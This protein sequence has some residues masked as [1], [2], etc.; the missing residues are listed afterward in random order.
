M[1][2]VTEFPSFTLTKAIQQRKTL[3]EAGKTPEEVQGELGTAFKLE[4]EKLTCLIN[5][6]EIASKHSGNLKRIL[7]M[8]LG[9]GETNTP[10]GATKIDELY[11]LPEILN[12][13]V[14]KPHEKSDPKNKNRGGRGGGKGGGKGGPKESPWGLSPEEKAAKNKKPDGA[15]PKTN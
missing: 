7:V 14:A 8:R 2:A 11:Y 6:V 10:A 12:L 5:A 13:T 3:T 9:E 1:K 4:G 15:P